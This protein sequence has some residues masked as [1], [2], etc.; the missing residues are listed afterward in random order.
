MQFGDFIKYQEMDVQIQTFTY[1]EWN[2][3]RN[4]SFKWY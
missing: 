3:L 1:K 2:T 4:C